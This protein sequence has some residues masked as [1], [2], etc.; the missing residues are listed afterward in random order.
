VFVI[1]IYEAIVNWTANRAARPVPYYQPIRRYF[2]FGWAG[3]PSRKSIASTTMIVSGIITLVF[4]VIHLLQFK[5]G[6][7][8][9]VT[10]AAS[11]TIGERDLYRLE[12]ENFSNALIVGFYAFCMVVIGFHLW[13]GISSALN[14]LG[15]DHPRSTPTLLKITRVVAVV[16]AGGFLFL[17]VWVFLVRG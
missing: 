14:S 10:S 1:H 2:G 7:E 13:H 12:I 16:L 17:P 5:F 6:P 4:V 8:Y 3:K 11:G 9:A 15:V